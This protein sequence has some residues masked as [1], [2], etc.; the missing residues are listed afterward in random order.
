MTRRDFYRTL[1]KWRSK[2]YLLFEKNK[3]LFLFSHPICSYYEAL[4]YFAKK[5]PDNDN[6]SVNNRD[7]KQNKKGD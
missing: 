5:A 3:K 6:L 4:I 7:E 2:E 1:V